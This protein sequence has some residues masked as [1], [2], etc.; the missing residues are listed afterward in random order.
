M[1]MEIFIYKN[2][3]CLLLL[4]IIFSLKYLILCLELITGCCL[5]SIINFFIFNMTNWESGVVRREMNSLQSIFRLYYFMI[6]IID[7]QYLD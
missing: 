3:H 7:T 1:D 5:I 4:Y 2:L 6:G